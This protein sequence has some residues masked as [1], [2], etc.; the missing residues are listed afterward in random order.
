MSAATKKYRL[1]F[2]KYCTFHLVPSRAPTNVRVRN[3][4]LNEFLVRWDPL[5]IQYANGRIL[6]YNVH[7]KSLQ[8]YYNSETIVRFNNT[9]L[10]QA[11]LSNLRTGER[12]Q[13]SVAAF[14]AVG[15]GP[16]SSL[17]YETKGK[18][19]I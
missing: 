1:L 14:T 3:H 5:P 15:T 16:R 19:N 12:Y 2:T 17:V 18:F 10:P 13:F 6:G 8:Y 11:I 9:D 4:G 7:Y